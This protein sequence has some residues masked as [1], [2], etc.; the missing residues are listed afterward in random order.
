M[1]PGLSDADK[2]RFEELREKLAGVET[3]DTAASPRPVELGPIDP[4]LAQPFEGNLSS[5]DESEWVAERK[6]DGTRIIFEKL[7]GEIRAYTRR[8]IER[9][10]T[11]PDVV[12]EASE[13]VPDGTILDSEFAFVDTD[14]R[15]HFIPIHS[16]SD[17][18]EAKD[19]DRILYVFDILVHDG[20]WVTSQPLTE[21]KDL[22]NE[23]ITAGE[24]IKHV[25]VRTSGFKSFYDDLVAENEEGIII[26]RA[27]SRYYVNTR[28]SHWQKV[29]AFSETDAIAVGYT[30]GEGARR[31]T[32]G[33]LVLTDGDQ[34]IGR[35]GSGF[36]N[37]DLERLRTG[38]VE[39][40]DRP[41]PPATVGMPYTP[42]EP[43]VVR[44]KYQSITDN[45]ELRAPVFLQTHP[46]KPIEEV[47]PIPD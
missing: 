33:A 19:L 10:D 24:S 6:Y 14:N 31:D 15:T 13:L 8:G 5:L 22:L 3:A 1:E 4:M 16:D 35:V 47:A 18:I 32:F 21:R 39:V 43:I 34:Y 23:T 11:M 29:K 42:I 7:S 9:A 28:S 2:D 27:A 40:D 26:K 46:D 37:E 44:V 17:K 20:D 45:T 41:V 36:S 38:F 30:E 25:P 12:A